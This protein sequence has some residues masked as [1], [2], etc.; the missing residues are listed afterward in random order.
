M[1]E[2]GGVMTTP[3]SPEGEILDIMELD[4]E[5]EQLRL[6]P[7]GCDDDALALLLDLRDEV[8]ER[9]AALLGQHDALTESSLVPVASLVSA[10]SRRRLRHRL[11]VLPA[12]AALVLA[13]TGVAAAL[14]NSPHEPLYP[15]HRLIFGSGLPS[16]AA[17]VEQDLAAAQVLLD[18]A[19]AE[20][21]ASRG[22]A[23][24]QAH[25]WLSDA[26]RLLPQAGS[27]TQ[28]LSIRL[29]AELALLTK[30][31]KPPS[32][33]G[34][35]PAP[36]PSE[37]PGDAATAPSDGGG[38]GT[39]ESAQPS[40]GGEAE[41]PET[42]VAPAQSQ[43]TPGESSAAAAETADSAESSWAPPSHTTETHHAASGGSETSSTAPSAGADH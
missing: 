16:S 7:G 8:D 43:P 21:Y 13:S 40:A 37:D 24:G 31:E 17:N 42:S 22:S 39:V 25:V 20:P 12:S 23:L 2:G 18:Q 35:V 38:D 4:Q 27:Q 36:T 19:A 5:I 11:A 33:V 9:A 28:T 32:A 6:G 26:Q 34:R 1:R 10:A 15:L 41:A 14:S 29:T 3:R 30:L